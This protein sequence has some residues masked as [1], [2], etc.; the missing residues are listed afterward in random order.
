MNLIITDL[1]LQ[2]NKQEVMDSKTSTTFHVSQIKPK[3]YDM[4][5]DISK[6]S[7]AEQ[8]ANLRTYKEGGCKEI[9]QMSNFP[10]KTDLSGDNFVEIVVDA[11]SNH[12]SLVIRPDDVWAAVM[13]QFSFYINKNAEEFRKKFVNFE[14]KRTLSV[15][16][17]GSIRAGNDLFVKLMTEEIHKNI[18]DPEVKKWIIPN[19]S[20]TTEND[21]V[22]IGVIFMATM[23]KY[24][25]YY[26]MGC[27]IPNMTLEGTIEDWKAILARLEKLKEYEL[28]KWYDL[29]KPVIQQFVDAK[30]GKV[31][32]DFWQRICHYKRNASATTYLSGWITV[33]CVFNK[34][35]DWRGEG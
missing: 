17:P 1:I 32:L 23:K 3:K 15:I 7:Y 8:V 2:P 13:T 27:G 34:D 22:S 20:T 11:Y 21:I 16:V 26:R 24:F 12:H 31:D 4:I 18:V 10:P 6:E 9:L 14:G 29:L 25:N 33:F 30:Q 19:F 28:E 5:Y 35:G